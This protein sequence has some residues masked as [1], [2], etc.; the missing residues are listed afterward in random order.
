MRWTCALLILLAAAAPARAQESFEAEVYT[1]IEASVRG[2][3]EAM[4]AQLTRAAMNDPTIDWRDQRKMAERLEADKARV[5]L[6]TYNKAA[7]FAYCGAE[8]ERAAGAEAP[9]SR[10]SGSPRVPAGQNLMLQACVEIK[11]SQMSKFLNVAS[12]AGVFF[13]ERIA[14]CGEHS[15][16]P[17]ARAGVAAVPISSRC[18]SRDFTTSRATS[19]A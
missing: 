8:A 2:E 11:S 12:Y 9:R 14:P 18:P 4:L 6:W 3:Y 10:S 17:R 5:K 1:Q 13:P 16:L 7:F 19:I 15:R